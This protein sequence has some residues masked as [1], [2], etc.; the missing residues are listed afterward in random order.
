MLLFDSCRPAALMGVFDTCTVKNKIRKE[1]RHQEKR[2]KYH[3]K[4]QT[5]TIK[6]T[7]NKN[8]LKKIYKFIQSAK[9]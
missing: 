8:Y 3:D 9:Y 4:Y 6:N 1:S 5:Y 2:W 7:G